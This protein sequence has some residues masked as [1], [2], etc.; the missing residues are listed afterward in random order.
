MAATDFCVRRLWRYSPGAFCFFAQPAYCTTF[1]LG[2]VQS[3]LLLWL[4]YYYMQ[5]SNNWSS[6]GIILRCISNT[7]E[8][9]RIFLALTSC[10]FTEFRKPRASSC[11]TVLDV[12]RTGSLSRNPF[13]LPFPFLPRNHHWQA[14]PLALQ[15]D[16]FTDQI[17]WSMLRNC[18]FGHGDQ[19]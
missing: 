11:Q 17:L 6:D 16:H 2:L 7:I 13:S 12:S 19:N 8:P 9:Q 1:R 5:L 18:V 14:K 10:P 4:Y 15:A 3:W